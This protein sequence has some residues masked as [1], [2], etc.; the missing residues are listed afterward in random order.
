MDTPKTLFSTLNAL[1]FVII[2]AITIGFL[3][4]ILSVSGVISEPTFKN[5]ISFSDL[6]WTHYLFM[7]LNLIVYSVFIYGLFRLRIVSKLFLNNTFYNSEL[8]KNSN[9][10]GKCF[11]LSGVFWWLIDGLSSIH[12]NNEFS[13]GVSEKTFIYL[14]IIVIGLFFMLTSRLFDRA[15]E[16]KNE[17]DLTI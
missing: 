6:G 9:L 8:G 16:L 3:I 11:I 15:L 14:F 10:A 2:L 7:A 13:I 5:D 1:I 17:N 12:F 4:T